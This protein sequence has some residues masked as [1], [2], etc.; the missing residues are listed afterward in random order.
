MTNTVVTAFSAKGYKEYGARLLESWG[1][2]N[3]GHELVVYTQDIDESFIG[4]E[5]REQTDIPGFVEFQD[6]WKYDLL[7]QGKQPIPGKWKQRELQIGYSYKFD[8]LKF[9]KMVA[10]MHHAANAQKTGTMIWI[11]GD[12]VIRQRLPRDLFT[13]W[14]P[15]DCAYAYLGREP[16]HTETGFVAFRLPDALPILD[17]WYAYYTESTFLQEDEWHSAFLFDRA[18]EQFPNIKGHNLTPGGSGHVIFQC[19]AG[20]YFMHNKGS[21]K[22]AGYSPEAFRNRK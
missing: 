21:R 5:Q 6:K 17:A 16:K 7:V 1:R 9:Q 8:G 4:I 14:L 20:D 22:S 12:N 15:D 19:S 11:D 18:R 2:N 10:V 3:N 13:R